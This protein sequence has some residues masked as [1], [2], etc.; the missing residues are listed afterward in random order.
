MWSRVSSPPTVRVTPAGAVF[1]ETEL[2]QQVGVTF[3]FLVVAFAVGV[4]LG[5]CCAWRRSRHGLAAVAAVA[6]STV[7]AAAVCYWTGVHVFGPDAS[8]QLASAP[9]GHRI[10]APLDLGTRIVFLGWPAGGLL[11]ALA[12]IWWWPRQASST[13]LAGSERTPSSPDTLAIDALR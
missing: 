4:G 7:A 5:F 13:P 11:G 1:G 9:V 6:L 12:A 2:D 3:W 8:A 10:T